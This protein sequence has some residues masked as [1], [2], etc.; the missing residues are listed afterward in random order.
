VFA[1]ACGNPEN[2]LV[3]LQCPPRTH[4]RC[5]KRIRGYCKVHTAA[6]QL[7]KTVEQKIREHTR[8]VLAI[9]ASHNPGCRSSQNSHTASLQKYMRLIEHSLCQNI[10]AKT[11]PQDGV[12]MSSRQDGAT[13]VAVKLRFGDSHGAMIGPRL[14]CREPQTPPKALAC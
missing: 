5:M 8:T 10:G 7:L 11:M 3:H 2:R 13:M 6:P 12:T 1:L 9:E 14:G 4:P